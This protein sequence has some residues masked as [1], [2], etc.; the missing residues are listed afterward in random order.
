MVE[1]FKRLGKRVDIFCKDWEDIIEHHHL[2][3][4]FWRHRHCEEKIAE[5]T[6]TVRS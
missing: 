2:Y 4:F 1:G 3:R 6:S 5:L